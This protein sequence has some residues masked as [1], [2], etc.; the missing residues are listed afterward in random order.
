MSK[1]VNTANF[2][3]EHYSVRITKAKKQISKAREQ[4]KMGLYY[5]DEFL[6]IKRNILKKYQ[7]DG[8]LL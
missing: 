6:Q 5:Y 4:Y 3:G 7:V 1:G 2:I 8:F